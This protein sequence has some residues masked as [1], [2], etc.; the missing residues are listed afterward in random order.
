VNTPGH[1]NV[2]PAGPVSC[3]GPSRLWV[4]FSGS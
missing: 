4:T 1:A 3:F 2:S